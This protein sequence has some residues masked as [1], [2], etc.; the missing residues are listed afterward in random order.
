MAEAQASPTQATTPQFT[1][2]FRGYDQVQVEEHLKKLTS[3]LA[4]AAR[5][6]DDATASVAE[7][8]KARS[9]AQKELAGTT[10]KLGNEQFLAKA[11][12]AVVAKITAR[13]ELAVAEVERLKYKLAELDA[14]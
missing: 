3:E 13:R 1:T 5:H 7:L 2:V 8:T 10:A 9:Y 11:P 6:R 12:D 4:S 14:R